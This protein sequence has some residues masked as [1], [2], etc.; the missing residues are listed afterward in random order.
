MHLAMISGHNEHG[1]WRKH[2]QDIGNQVVS[3]TQLCCVVIRKTTFM[4]N[5]VNAVVIGINKILSCCECIAN[6]DRDAAGCT[7]PHVLDPIKVS[8]RESA[9][10]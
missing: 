9:A 1:V 4:G 5:L 8:H 2:R 7:P 6:N 10:L 3:R